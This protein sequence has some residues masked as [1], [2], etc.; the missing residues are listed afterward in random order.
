MDRTVF[1]CNYHRRYN[2]LK[3]DDIKG[4]HFNAIL[5]EVRLKENAYNLKKIFIEYGKFNTLDGDTEYFKDS[6]KRHGYGYSQKV[7][8]VFV[9]GLTSEIKKW[10]CILTA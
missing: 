2:G 4:I 6:L 7:R 5:N 9:D 8:Y 10:H 1:L 3:D